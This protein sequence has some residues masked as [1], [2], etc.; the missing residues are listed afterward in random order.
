MLRHPRDGLTEEVINSL[1]QVPGLKVAG[2]TSA[3]YFK[4][5]NEDLRE[6]GRQLGVAHV[7]EGSVR[8][9]NDRLRVTVQLIKVSDGFHVMSQT[10][11]RQ[12]N[13]AFAIQT[14]IANSVASTLKLKLAPSVAAAAPKDRDPEAYRL[15]LVARAQ[16]RRF[17]LDELTS[18]RDAYRKLI[19]LEPDNADVY[20]GYASATVMLAQNH[21]AI[22]FKTAEA[23]ARAAITKAKA[24]D[25]TSTEAYVAEGLLCQVLFVR[26]DNQ[27][28]IAGAEASFR[29]AVQLSPKDPDALTFYGNALVTR[30]PVHAIVYLKRAVT[31]DPLNRVGLNALAR[32]YVATGQNAGAERLYLSTVSL[33]PDFVDAKQELAELYIREGRL[34]RAEPWMRSA[35]APQSD[36]SAAIELANL[37]FNLGMPQQAAAALDT[38]KGQPVAEGVVKAVRLMVAGDYRGLKALSEQELKAGGDPFW[39]SA[40]SIA[41]VL[42]QD[43]EGARQQMLISSP[44]LFEP[45]PTV[46]EKLAPQAVQAALICQRLGDQGQARRILQSL[47]AVTGPKPGRPQSPGVHL[48]RAKAYAVLGDKEQALKELRVAVEGGYRSVMDLEY[49]LRMDRDP[50]LQALWPDPRFR[51]LI[52]Q[53]EADNARMRQAL[54]GQGPPL[55]QASA[56]RRYRI[57]NGAS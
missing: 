47:L 8:R 13:D 42:V 14:E 1:A 49:F 9:E 57:P 38:L 50:L 30:D 56:P 35:A 3:F 37:Y 21:L 32:A 10:Y 33:Y 36:P 24:L 51:A 45:N 22:D 11:D 20:A 43:Y 31:V 15:E 12:M 19:K 18:A 40:L 54:L 53:I 44:E 2:R 5:K 46:S 34:D 27:P 29:K 55:R 17:G 7:V 4:G 16:L 41:D 25:P 52:A 28:C 48:V 39:L 23:Q 6:V 26:S